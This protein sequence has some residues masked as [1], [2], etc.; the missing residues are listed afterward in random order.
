[1]PSKLN[2]KTAHL[3]GTRFNEIADFG[4]ILSELAHCQLVRRA[5]VEE[6]Y[7]YP[8]AENDVSVTRYLDDDHATIWSETMASELGSD[9]RRPYDKFGFWS[10]LKHG[11]D[12]QAAHA[13]LVSIGIGDNLYR[14]RE[15]SAQGVIA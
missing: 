8:N 3:A 14:G 10:R 7:H 2:G 13:E 1:L 4:L 9:V 11:G 5:G 15:S 12:F 6:H